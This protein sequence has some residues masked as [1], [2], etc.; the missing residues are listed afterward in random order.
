MREEEEEESFTEDG[1]RIAISDI[2][3]FITRAYNVNEMLIRRDIR[4]VHNAN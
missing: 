2:S 3:N 4:C 1:G